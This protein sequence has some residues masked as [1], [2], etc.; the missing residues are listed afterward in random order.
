MPSPAHSMSSVVS[1]PSYWAS[2]KGSGRRG[3]V[4]ACRKVGRSP[5]AVAPQPLT[6]RPWPAGVAAHCSSDTSETGWTPSPSVSGWV[7]VSTATS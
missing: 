2:Q 6:R 1:S 4:A 3:T 7:S 5:L